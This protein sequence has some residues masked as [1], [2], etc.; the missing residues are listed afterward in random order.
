MLCYERLR[1]LD[2]D[3]SIQR[4]SLD[5]RQ[6]DVYIYMY[7]SV[8][9]LW[10]TKTREEGI[11][12]IPLVWD[13]QVHCS[14]YSTH[15][16]TRDKEREKKRERKR[17]NQTITQPADDIMISKKKKRESERKKRERESIN[18]ATSRWY[19]D[20]LFPFFLSFFLLFFHSFFFLLFF[21]SPYYRRC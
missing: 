21:F 7:V 2:S 19:H 20:N 17:E 12:Q 5:N 8:V 18:H 6:T 10:E 4:M 3:R 1:A 11:L 13:T 14:S 16:N 15:N 9:V